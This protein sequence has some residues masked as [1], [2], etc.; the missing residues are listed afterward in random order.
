MFLKTL[1]SLFLQLFQKQRD[2]TDINVS[3]RFHD[4]G[5][6]IKDKFIGTDYGRQEKD[7]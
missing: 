1:I 2:D 6:I 7:Q 5:D 3:L 4:R